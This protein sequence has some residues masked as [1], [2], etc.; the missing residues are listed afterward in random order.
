MQ[1]CVTENEEDLVKQAIEGDETAIDGLVRQ[2]HSALLTAALRL[3]GY[4]EHDAEEAVQ[5]A[6]ISVVRSISTLRDPSRWKPW[7]Y[8]I[9]RNSCLRTGKRRPLPPDV[10]ADVV[11]DKIP[12]A[13]ELRDVAVWIQRMPPSYR[14][15]VILRY[16]QHLQYAEIAEVLGISI[17]TAKSNV[18]RGVLW[19]QKNVKQEE[20]KHD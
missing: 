5:D 4:R 15:S 8:Q 9:L 3:T 1:G 17:G 11:T 19:L 2:W 10:A 18:H 6:W 12:E 13:D 7:I 14:E 20:G 16:M